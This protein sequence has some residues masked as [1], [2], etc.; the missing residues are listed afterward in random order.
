MH[1]GRLRERQG[2]ADQTA[3]ALP[4]RQVEPLHR[5]GQAAALL[6]R[7]M[8]LARDYLLIRPIEVGVTR[9]ALVRL[10]QPLP[11][12]AAGLGAAIPHDHR[13]HLPALISN[14]QPDP[15]LLLL[16]SHETPDLV[17]LDRIARLRHEQGLFQLGEGA[18]FSLSHLT[19]VLRLILKTRAMP[20]MEARSW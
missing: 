8:Y 14:R 19:R 9:E 20:R 10:R 17:Q 15:D 5:V 6:A 11:E 13:P 1:Q 12:L 7:L 3:D 16:A 2:L 4:K 18:P